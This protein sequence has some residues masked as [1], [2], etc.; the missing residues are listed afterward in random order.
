MT[1]V[2]KGQAPGKM[3]R[4][5]FGARFRMQFYDP[6]YR[7]HDAAIEKLEAIAWD[8][9]QEGR[10]APLTEKA[11][12]EFADPDYD[13]SV[14]WRATRD[15]LHAAAAKQRESATRSRVLVVCASSRND[16]TCPGEISKTYRLSQAVAEQLRSESIEV[17]LLDLS[18]VTSDPMRHIHPC[19]GVSTAM[20]LCHWPCSCYPNHATDQTNDWM[21]EIYERWTAAHGVVILTPCIG[22]RCRAR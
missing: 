19:K 11:G 20:P 8:A 2:R 7:P 17:D 18:L 22:I 4:Q 16:G 13:L 10:K 14:E 12:P 9:Y 3:S 6:A 15:R 1:E 5:E 21:A